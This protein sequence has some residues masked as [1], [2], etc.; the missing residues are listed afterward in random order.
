VRI[1]G[2]QQL[3]D[4]E[5]EQRAEDDDLRSSAHARDEPVRDQIAEQQGRLEEY[6][7]RGPHGGRPAQQRKH[8]LPRQ[9][10]D[11]KK[12]G[13]AQKNRDGKADRDGTNARRGPVHG[14]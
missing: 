11:E 13:A 14:P 9:W 10:L 2:E 7:A 6:E 4:G 12:K 1:D 8:T 5:S 3:N